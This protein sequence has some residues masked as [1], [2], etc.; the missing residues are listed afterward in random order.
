MGEVKWILESKKYS[1]AETTYGEKKIDKC[2]DEQLHRAAEKH[3][4]M[5]L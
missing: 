5:S 2:I 4:Q 1:R 3:D